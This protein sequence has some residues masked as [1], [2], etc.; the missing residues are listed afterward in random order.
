MDDGCIELSASKVSATIGHCYVGFII[1]FY[2]MYFPP[3]TGDL[4]PHAS[5]R[6]SNLTIYELRH[7]CPRAKFSA[8]ITS[9]REN[10]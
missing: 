5:L 7:M 6:I 10:V 2:E 3:L 8:Q 1:D 9:L 4:Q